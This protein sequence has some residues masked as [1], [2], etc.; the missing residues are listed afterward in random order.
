MADYIITCCSPVD[1]TPEYMQQIGVPFAKFHFTIN[2]QDYLDDMGQ[3]MS[4]E[5]FYS[6][7]EKGDKIVTSQ[8]NPYEYEEL[9][10]P[11]LD[12]GMDVLH[13]CT[14]SGISSTYNSANIAANEMREK[15]PDRKIY[16]VD[17]V[18]V[19]GGYGLLVDTLAEKRDEGLSIDELHDWAEKNRF[20]CHFW[21]FAG[22]LKY[23]VNG[24]RL[25]KTAGLMGSLLKICPLLYWNQKGQPIPYSKVR[26]VK[27]CAEA[28]VE[29]MV[30]TCRDGLDYCGKAFIT[31]SVAPDVAQY[32]ADLVRSKFP[33]LKCEPHVTQVGPTIGNYTGPTSLSLGFWSDVD[34]PVE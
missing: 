15:Y 23:L 18:M 10:T 19:S 6:H 1:Q 29:R 17:S 3:M 9:W 7:M 33:R 13:V 14:S 25:S 27:K 22:Q 4:Y 34:K 30:K 24:G 31:H 20:K 2:G 21:F 28:M 16:I 11:Y 12:K 5:E 8:V 32:I 26:T